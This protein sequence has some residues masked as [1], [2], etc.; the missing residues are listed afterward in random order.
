MFYVLVAFLLKRLIPFAI[1]TSVLCMY[2][3]IIS[4]FKDKNHAFFFI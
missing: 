3:K 1:R 2:S 4:L